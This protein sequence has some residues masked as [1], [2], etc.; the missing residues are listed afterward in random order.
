VSDSA[1]SE[2]NGQASLVCRAPRALR[3][4][5]ANCWNRLV[6]PRRRPAAEA[7]FDSL[8]QALAAGDS[9]SPGAAAPCAV[10]LGR[11]IATAA[12]LGEFQVATAWLR[13]L[14]AMQSR[15]G[16]GSEGDSAG[17]F[18][19]GGGRPSRFHTSQA[20]RGLL[21][22]EAAWSERAR[23]ESAEQTPGPAEASW[24]AVS[25]A[26]GGAAAFLARQVDASGLPRLN[27]APSGSIDRWGPRS[28]ALAWLPPLRDAARLL[29][30]AEWERLAG[31]SLRRQLNA[32]DI[33][34]WNAPTH[35]WAYGIEALADLGEH[36][37]AR[38]ALRRAAARQTPGGDVPALPDEG[39]ISS[40]GLA[41]LVGT[42]HKLGGR[43][44]RHR[45]G[46]ALAAL[47]RRQRPDGG[48]PGSWGRQARLHAV[49]PL[50]AALFLEA[51][52]G[53]VR[54][55]FASAENDF[56]AEIDAGDGRLAAVLEACRR[57]GPAPRILDVG[58]GK[59]RFLRHLRRAMPGATLVGVDVA[60][61]A[62]ACLPDGVAAR[63]GDLLGIPAATGEFDA[64]L[65]V[66]ALEHSLL[67]GRAIAELCRVVRPGGVIAVIDKNAS[68][69]PLSDHRPWER[70]FR[71]EEVSFW[72]ASHADEVHVRS[73]AH[74]SRP[75]PSGLFLCW[76][77]RRRAANSRR[78]AA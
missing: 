26:I 43:D 63:P 58:C 14:L 59:G 6:R 73:V 60:A 7:A 65:C 1:V 25:A 23:W 68:H 39:W 51:L 15:D 44:E 77:A 30:E 32:V 69:Q 47:M 74:G 66:E 71:P 38:A 57:L 19:D 24:P 45:A 55:A 4:R 56:P 75:A 12:R 61:Q 10:T 52:H 21:A 11:A 13:D 3:R 64:A 2:F 27:D 33:T 49:C 28:L 36:V 22:L 20:L 40:A 78:Q 18:P 67:P 37:T 41:I 8:T 31:R 35:W 29:N 54:Q 34:S 9:H 70:W 5:L 17:S 76:T 16:G 72:L 48:F 46:L 42:W 53:Q 50:T 62:L